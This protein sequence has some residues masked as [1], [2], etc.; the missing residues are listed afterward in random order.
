MTTL[1]VPPSPADSTADFNTKAFALLGALP[2]F[3]TEA[4]ALETAVVADATTA[5]TQAGI[6][7][8]QAN[9]ATTN[10]AAQVA[11]ATTQANLATTQANN[12]ATSANTANTK[13]TEASVSAASAETSRIEASKLNLGSKTTAPTLDNQ[14]STLRTGATYYDTTLNRWRVYNGSAWADGISAVAGVSSINGLAGDLTGFVTTTA[15]QTLTNKTIVDPIVTLGSTQGTAGQ[16]PVSQGAGLPPVWG[17]VGGI[18]N[19]YL[20]GGTLSGNLNAVLDTAAYSIPD[21]TTLAASYTLLFPSNVT[22]RT[23]FNLTDGWTLGLTASAN[24][25]HTPYPVSCKHGIWP[26]GTYTP[27]VNATYTETTSSIVSAV[28]L[29]AD[30]H[31]LLFS[32]DTV[33]AFNSSTNTFGTA[34][35]TSVISGLQKLHIVSS[36]SFVVSGSLS[37]G[38]ENPGAQAFSVSGTTITAGTAV[39]LGNSPTAEQAKQPVVQLSATSFVIFYGRSTSFDVAAKAFTVSGTT[40]TA[41]T[42]SVIGSYAESNATLAGFIVAAGVVSST[43]LLVS[44]LTTGGG[45]ATTRA[46]ASRVLSVSGTTI[47]LR[48]AATSGGNINGELINAFVAFSQTS[49]AV[50]TTSGVSGTHNWFGITV[51]GTTTTIGTV[52]P[53]NTPDFANSD[54]TAS[55][56]VVTGAGQAI[57]Y[58]YDDRSPNED[59][60]VTGLTISG[61]TLTVGASVAIDTQSNNLIAAPFIRD[62]E[63]NS[64]VFVR[65]PDTSQIAKL[66]ISGATVSIDY[67]LPEA[68]WVYS[69]TL[70]AASVNIGGTWYS[71]TVTDLVAGTPYLI[72]PTRVIVSRS[73][74]GYVA[75]SNLST[76]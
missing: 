37:P 27:Q 29:S 10:G 12:A 62:A 21:L 34:V 66:S 46:F 42:E 16:V 23:T 45:S 36:T 55:P 43:S 3:V 25:I 5:T 70:N 58:S 22:P 59:S 30:L 18:V 15:A 63:T 20:G 11:L 40:I 67:L 7:T 17:A 24:Q 52:Q 61:T 2:T 33:V 64:I 60:Y 47:T 4:N 65:K 9:L 14:G 50:V 54:I 28:A 13:A 74:V 53:L 38:G 57:L 31:I 26:G 75:L 71:R 6:A 32:N 19:K 49:F 39:S 1:P 8:T 41:G 51:S 56:S 48:T 35:S 76:F 69:E 72:S 44:Y 68:R 73:G